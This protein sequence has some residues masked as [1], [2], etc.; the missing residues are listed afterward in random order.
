MVVFTC[1]YC[2]E[3]VKKPAVSK[4]YDTRCRGRNPNL[5]CV[6]CLKDFRGTEYEAHTK[7]ISESERYG[8]KG[9]F[10]GNSVNKGNLK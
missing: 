10:A 8:A 4:H 6:D 1:S 3:P 2:G 9:S 5:T 7:C